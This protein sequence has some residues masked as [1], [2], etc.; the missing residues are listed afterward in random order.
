[1]LWVVCVLGI[2][3]ADASVGKRTKGRQQAGDG[4]CE[5]K[6]VLRRS[7]PLAHRRRKTKRVDGESEVSAA[8]ATELLTL[9]SHQVY[10]YCLCEL[11]LQ[12]FHQAAHLLSEANRGGRERRSDRLRCSLPASLRHRLRFRQSVLRLSQRRTQSQS[13]GLLVLHLRKAHGRSFGEHK[14]LQSRVKI[15]MLECIIIFSG[16]WRAFIGTA[17]HRKRSTEDVFRVGSVV[18]DIFDGTRHS[19]T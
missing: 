14:S 3:G 11:A 4:E 12:V 6:C 9:H 1:M 8:A 7:R 10:S 18:A 2:Y 17:F 5:G 16:K 15:I 19:Q 13:W